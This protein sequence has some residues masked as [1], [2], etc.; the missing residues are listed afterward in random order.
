MKNTRESFLNDIYYHGWR[1]SGDF[2]FLRRPETGLKG[3]EAK[4]ILSVVCL[5]WEN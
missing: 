3:L 5:K 1:R 2:S 4:E